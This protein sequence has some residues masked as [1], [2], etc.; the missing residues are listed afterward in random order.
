M[1]AAPAEADEL[2]TSLVRFVCEQ[3]GYPEELVEL[4]ADLEADLGIDSIKKAQ[5]LGE[6]RERYGFAVAGVK[7]L[8]LADFPTL[9][10][11]REFIETEWRKADFRGRVHADQ[12]RDPQDRQYARHARY[13]PR[14]DRVPLR[15]RPGTRPPQAARD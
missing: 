12:E 9:R 1:V 4:D 5:L 8:S 10:S 7:Q 3:T 14:A 2:T 15:N 6:M 13:A 11:I